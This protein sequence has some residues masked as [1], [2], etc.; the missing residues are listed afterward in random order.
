MSGHSKWKS[1]KNKKAVTDAKRSGVFTKLANIITVAAREKGPDPNMNPSLRAAVAKA[2]SFNMPNENIE[3]AIKKGSGDSEEKLETIIYEGFGPGGSALLIE[4]ITNNRNRTNQELK[5]LLSRNG[6]SFASEGSVM[7]L[8]DKFGKIIAEKGGM[9]MEE[10]E[11]EA[12]DAGAEEIKE[13]D[14]EVVIFTKPEN[15]FKAAK[16]LEEKGIK[17]KESELDYVA[18]N[19]LKIEDAE[20]KDSVEKLFELIDENNDVQNIY[21]NVEF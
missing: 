20:T 19:P 9:E 15:L 21:S 11:L 10:L 16:I 13:E 6:G 5:T 8:F 18:K 1:I 17:M 4:T 2:R 3:R 14:G 7:W 12:I